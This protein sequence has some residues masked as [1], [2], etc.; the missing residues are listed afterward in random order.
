MSRPDYNHG[1]W[2]SPR[3]RLVAIKL[4]LDV[5]SRHPLTRIKRL[6]HAQALELLAKKVKKTIPDFLAMPRDEAWLA[7]GCYT[8]GPWGGFKEVPYD[9]LY[10]PRT[11]Y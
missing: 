4:G 11:Y 3:A 8:T 9:P 2:P 6:T 10:G 7:L 1:T 5:T